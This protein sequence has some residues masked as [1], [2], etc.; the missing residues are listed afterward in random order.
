MREAAAVVATGREGGGER[1]EGHVVDEEVRRSPPMTGEG[2]RVRERVATPG[3]CSGG[4][5]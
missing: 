2:R 3:A 1:L 5:G 4:A